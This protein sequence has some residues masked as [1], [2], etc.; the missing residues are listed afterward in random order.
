MSG[1]LQLFGVMLAFTLAPISAPKESIIFEILCHS[2]FSSNGDHTDFPAC[3]WA[4]PEL[5][6]LVVVTDV[7]V[8]NDVDVSVTDLSSDVGV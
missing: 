6:L 4:A 3:C 2:S 1:Y 8:N 5:V 7:V